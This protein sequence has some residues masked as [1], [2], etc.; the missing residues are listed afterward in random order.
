MFIYIGFAFLHL[1][2]FCMVVYMHIN[3]FSALGRGHRLAT[4]LARV[5]PKP[6]SPAHPGQR[7]SEH[8]TSPRYVYARGEP[9]CSTATQTSKVALEKHHPRRVSVLTKSRMI[10][11]RNTTGSDTVYAQEMLSCGWRFSNSRTLF[12]E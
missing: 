2:Y 3:A 8:Q 12:V 11:W 1:I 6:L 4:V 7:L 10:H 9:R 5:P